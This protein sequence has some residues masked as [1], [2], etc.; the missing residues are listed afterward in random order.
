VNLLGCLAIGALVGMADSRQLISPQLRIFASIGVLGGFTTFSAFGFE[1][2]ALA[3][4][5]DTL[6]AVWNVGLHLVLGLGLVWLGYGLAS[7]RWTS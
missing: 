3:R 4:E 7:A 1:T 6:R 5:G 2:F